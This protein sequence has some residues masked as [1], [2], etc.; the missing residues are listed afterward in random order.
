MRFHQGRYLEAL[1]YWKKNP[2]QFENQLTIEISLFYLAGIKRFR[3][4]S[5]GDFINQKYFNM[6]CRVAGQFP[7]M[8][9]LAF[10][11]SY[12]IDFSRKP[13]NLI[14]RYSLDSS[15]EVV[16]QVDLYAKVV[17]DFSEY[18]LKRGEFRCMYRE[19]KTINCGTCQL[20]WGKRKTV[21]FKKH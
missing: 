21:V 4:H 7:R 11:K 9:F 14:I 15:T 3:F 6:C 18:K 8:K 10:T 19:D 16:P 1:N 2:E 17:E 12:K 13:R 20:C 5:S